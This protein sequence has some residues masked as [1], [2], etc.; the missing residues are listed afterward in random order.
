MSRRKIKLSVGNEEQLVV[1][2]VQ[3]DIVIA[4]TIFIV[5]SRLSDGADFDF[6]DLAA[7]CVGNLCWETDGMRV[8]SLTV[9]VG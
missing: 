1:S 9:I 8:V 6:S 3:N 5:V 4:L 7:H 2:F